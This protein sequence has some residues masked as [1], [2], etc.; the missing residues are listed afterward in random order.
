MEARY[1]SGRSA[2]ADEF[3]YAKSVHSRACNNGQVF[4]RR[5][6]HNSFAQCAGRGAAVCQGFV[7]IAP[8]RECGRPELNVTQKKKHLSHEGITTSANISLG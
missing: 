7:I 5:E 4:R 1:V 2:M 6:Q 8:D 3:N